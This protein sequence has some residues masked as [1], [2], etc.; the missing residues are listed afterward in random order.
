M[1]TGQLFRHKSQ[2]VPNKKWSGRTNLRPN[3]G[4]FWTKGPKRGR[5][6]KNCFLLLSSL[7][8]GK[9]KKSKTFPTHTVT[10]IVL[11]LF[12][13]SFN[14]WKLLGDRISFL[15]GHGTVN[16]PAD[17]TSVADPGCLS[18]IPDSGSRILIYTHPGSRISDP[19]SKNS[20]KRERWKKISCHTF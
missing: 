4:Q 20:N 3:F 1:R 12:P 8:L 2:K 19:G 18:R 17:L 9:Y 10:K 16:T 6:K 15:S 11:F 7:I 13:N 14:K 5:L